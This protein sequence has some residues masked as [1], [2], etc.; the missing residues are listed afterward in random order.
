MEVLLRA[1]AGLPG[2]HQ[3]FKIKGSPAVVAVPISIETVR[4]A[5]ELE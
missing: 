4:P 3:L 5:K 1:A 2:S